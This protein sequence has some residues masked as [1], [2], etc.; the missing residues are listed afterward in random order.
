MIEDNSDSDQEVIDMTVG[1]SP[2][3][4]YGLPDGEDAIYVYY[5]MTERRYQHVL[6]RGGKSRRSAG[7]V[8][9]ESAVAAHDSHFKVDR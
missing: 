5:D 1:D 9:A 3:N 8:E 7:L 2:V 4:E 6:L